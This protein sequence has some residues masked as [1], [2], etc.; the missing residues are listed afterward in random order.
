MTRL[1]PIGVMGTG[2]SRVVQQAAP[3]LGTRFAN[4]TTSGRMIIERESNSLMKEVVMGLEARPAPATHR[5]EP[6]DE[7][8]DE[9]AFQ[10]V[11]IWNG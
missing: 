3:R 8:V 2:R 7:G 5:I 6:G 11:A 9:F 10:M 1:W 4:V